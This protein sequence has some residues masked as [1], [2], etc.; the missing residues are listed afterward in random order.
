MGQVFWRGWLPGLLT[1]ALA[2]CGGSDGVREIVAPAAPPAP[3]ATP[4]SS[5]AERAGADVPGGV[6]EGY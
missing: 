6:V 4:L 1:I 5:G 3:T 2:G